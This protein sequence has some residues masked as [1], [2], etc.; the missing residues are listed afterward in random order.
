MIT[1]LQ[2]FF[3]YLEQNDFPITDDIRAKYKELLQQEVEG[4]VIDA[5]N[6]EQISRVANLIADHLWDDYMESTTPEIR[7]EDIKRQVDELQQWMNSEFG[8]EEE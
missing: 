4:I 3:E 7:E 6:E 1:P 5:A 2:T 8:D